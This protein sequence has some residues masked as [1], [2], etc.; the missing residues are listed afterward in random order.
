MLTCKE[1]SRNRAVLGIWCSKAMA[2][3]WR[4]EMPCIDSALAVDMTF[5]YSFCHN[6][7]NFSS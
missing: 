2:M 3:D 5:S 6:S 4:R 1:E 7:N